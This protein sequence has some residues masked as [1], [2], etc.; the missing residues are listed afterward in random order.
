MSAF[1]GLVQIAVLILCTAFLRFAMALQYCHY[2]AGIAPIKFW[3]PL[4]YAFLCLS[5]NSAKKGAEY[6]LIWK[7]EGESTLADLIQSK[8]FPYNVGTFLNHKVLY[9]IISMCRRFMQCL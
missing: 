5:Q 2:L 9:V 4:V 1:E 8:E 6:W 7:F 3:G